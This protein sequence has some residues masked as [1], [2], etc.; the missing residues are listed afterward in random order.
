MNTH[1]NSSCGD[2]V[3][4]SQN[5]RDAQ[6]KAT[7]KR[8]FS[9]M[10]EDQDLE[11]VQPESSAPNSRS[12]TQYQSDATNRTQDFAT[13][14]DKDLCNGCVDLNLPA[15]LRAFIEPQ[16]GDRQYPAP[17]ETPARWTHPIAKVGCRYKKPEISACKLC[18]TLFSSRMR[19]DVEDKNEN[20]SSEDRGEEI[21][22]LSFL[23][24]A[25]LEDPMQKR[26]S[27]EQAVC[28]VLCH[29]GFSKDNHG[30]VDDYVNTNGCVVLVP[31]VV[32]PI[33][34][35]PQPIPQSFDLYTAKL[36][37]RYCTKNHRLLCTSER[38]PVHGVQVIDCETLLVEECNLD[39]PYIALSYVWGMAGDICEA[40]RDTNGKKR[41]PQT[42]SLVIEDSI[43]VTKALGYRYLWI[44]KF[45]IDQ[46]SSDLKHDQIRQMDAIYRNS[47]LT[48]ISAAGSDENHGL[49][50]VGIRDRSKQPIVKL[51]DITVMWLPKDPHESIAQ[52]YWST[53][54]WTFQEALLSRRRLVFTDEQIYFECNTMNCFES[55]HCPL[56]ELHV[57]NKTK[58]YEWL[59]AGVFGRTRE[60]R[61]GKLNRGKRPLND[62]F[63]LYLSNVEDYTAR[64]LRFDEDSLNAFQGILRRFSVQ[65]YLFG[66]VWGLCYPQAE[67]FREQCFAH[68][69]TWMHIES[70]HKP[71]RRTAF[72][73]WTWA[74]WAGSIKY[75]SSSGS[76]LWF[77]NS[78]Q[79]LQLG[80]PDGSVVQLSDMALE[81]RY[82]VLH[83]TAP[84]MSI[85]PD[86]YRRSASE[87]MFWII[88]GQNAKL[89]W[90]A[91]SRAYDAFINDFT[92]MSRWQ[93]IYIG[94]IPLLS[95]VMILEACPRT[96]T[97]QRVGMFLIRRLKDATQ[98][99]RLLR[100]Q[101]VRTFQVV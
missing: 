49:P 3:L 42:L 10:A 22:A 2:D 20:S 27:T 6:I 83:V 54:G 74:G 59:R 47:E 94:S 15:L 89:S 85:T 76:R 18:P 63:R 75:H 45:C 37:L 58:T 33:I 4:G 43:K 35:M 52:S 23:A 13:F 95:F 93:L 62:I 41:L 19:I 73:S 48:I 7:R 100:M 30:V 24:N 11:S 12:V 32:D 55:V 91:D 51:H 61:Y 98:V 78:P 65:K 8:D 34:F 26:Q 71:R 44:D 28:L 31:N 64:N 29:E 72:P 66:N 96:E 17:W 38:L 99:P 40:Y 90:S 92:N 5:E 69:L 97:W 39:T 9:T 80:C 56:D 68:S 46:N 101:Q 70:S 67:S 57:R 21:C 14:E 50:G 81:D 82:P 36:W 77:F 16:C 88:L 60:E 84:T 25:G 86:A 53:R 1:S 79:K 87:E